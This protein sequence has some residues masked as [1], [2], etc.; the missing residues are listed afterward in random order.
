M[1]TIWQFFQINKTECRKTGLRDDEVY[2]IDKMDM[3]P[4]FSITNPTFV[5]ALQRGNEDEKAA[6]EYLANFRFYF[7]LWNSNKNICYPPH[8]NGALFAH[9]VPNDEELVLPP[10]PTSP[11]RREN[12]KIRERRRG[13]PIGSPLEQ[14]NLLFHHTSNQRT[15]R[16]SSSV[17]SHKEPRT[18]TRIQNATKPNTTITMPFKS[19]FLSSKVKARKPCLLS[20]LQ[21][22]HTPSLVS[23][24]YVWR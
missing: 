21:S 9:L 10:P 2:P 14:A 4:I 20:A 13:D 8:Y 16:S 6:G 18:P 22:T 24:T 15:T 5:A 1:R 17:Y 19:R 7:D 23:V 3:D 11:P 12:L